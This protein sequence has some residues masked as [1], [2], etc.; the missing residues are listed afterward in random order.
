MVTNRPPLTLSGE[1]EMNTFILILILGNANGLSQG[2]YEFTN[3]V[4]CEQVK[5]LIID[6]IKQNF[7]MTSRLRAYCVPKTIGRQDDL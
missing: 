5:N 7:T 6:D 3:K 4:T 2:G 1:R